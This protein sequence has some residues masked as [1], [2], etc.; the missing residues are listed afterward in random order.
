M[1]TNELPPGGTLI[2]DKL[3]FRIGDVARLAGVKP[4]VLRFW[5]SEFPLISPDKSGS[6]HRVY[7]RTDV[8]TILLIKHLLYQERYSIEGARKRIN[9]LRRGGELK[10]FKQEKAIVAAAPETPEKKE[11]LGELRGLTRELR[12]L[13]RTPL[14]QFFSS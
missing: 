1:T 14:S 11:R 4:Y 5:E 10:A 12:S 2:P 3:F 8:E 7:R 6:G 13:A 9:E